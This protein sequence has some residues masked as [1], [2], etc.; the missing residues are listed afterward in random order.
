MADPKP[1]MLDPDDNDF[2][3]RDVEEPEEPEETDESRNREES[4]TSPDS[5]EK[6]EDPRP[7]RITPGTIVEGKVVETQDT[8][9]LLELE[10]QQE[11]VTGTLPYEN[12]KK[13]SVSEGDQRWVKVVERDSSTDEVLL[14]ERKAVEERSWS[15]VV[16]AE[17]NG[18]SVEGTIKKKIK[19]GFLVELT[20]GLTAFMPQSHLSLSPKKNHDRYIDKSFEFKVLEFDKDDD[21]VVLSRREH[22]EE[23]RKKEQ[24]DFFS[25]VEIGEWLE[26]TVKNIV[27]FGAFIN[28]GPVDGLLHKNDIAWGSVRDVKNHIT[29]GEEIEV[30][31]LDTT[32]DEGKVSL[33]LKQKYPDPWEDINEKYEEGSETTGEIVDVWSD[34]VFVRLE[35]DV[36]GKIE[37]SELSWTKTWDH[38]RDQFQEGQKVDVKILEIDQERRRISMSRKQTQR[39]PW[40]IL[41]KR[42]PEGTVL[43][44]P[45]VDISEE[46]VNV[47]LLENVK[48]I[49]RRENIRW[50]TDD[51]DL[52]EEFSIGDK[53]Q[54]KVLTLNSESQVVELGMK[55]T[56]PDPWVQKV[57]E[58]PEGMTLEGKVTSVVKFG[59]FV[60]IEDGLEGLVHVSEMSGGKRVN[61]FEQVEEGD[62]V[63]VKVLE[64]DEEE[65]KIDLSIQAYHEEKDKE[66]AEEYLSDNG[67]SPD[68]DMTFGELLG[69]DLESAMED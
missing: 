7:R 39:N 2:D 69:D 48:G 44:A 34:G 11:D 41:Q 12:L 66:E 38:P 64:I 37:E 17:R 45:I 56:M 54:C 28:L 49:I 52:F 20:R 10:A 53:V 1:T 30:K 9:A 27:D 5:D 35:R 43:S 6:E 55:Q 8:N 19:G 63:G 33:G 59:A 25:D 14:N 29:M 31:I 61:P 58:Y 13:G 46:M 51:L 26:G 62:E 3:F 47:Q 67:E 50:N 4:D 68:D 57:R 65:H 42:F 18:T 16:E 32:P 15:Q 60:E 36:E 22:L 24:D 40:S 23:E 21:N